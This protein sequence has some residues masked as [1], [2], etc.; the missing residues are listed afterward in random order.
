MLISEIGQNYLGDY[1]LAQKYVNKLCDVEQLD[2]LTFQVREKK[3]RERKPHLY[4]DF[5]NYKELCDITKKKDKLFGVALVDDELLSFF[6]D[7]GV[8]FYKVIRDGVYNRGLLRKLG[9]TKKPIIISLGVCSGD[10]IEELTKF[11]SCVPGDFTLL[12]TNRDSVKIEDLDLSSLNKL[13]NHWTQVSYGSHCED[14]NNLLLACSYEPKDIL[15]YVKD[16]D[17]DK[18]YPDDVWAIE[19]NQVSDIL[20]KVKQ[21]EKNK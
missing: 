21:M 11:L 19:L 17:R 3:H 15:F 14:P 4:F 10:D 13:K 1:C 5:K 16:D 12:Y 7:V 18:K 8:D 9:E 2:G 6:E 20:K